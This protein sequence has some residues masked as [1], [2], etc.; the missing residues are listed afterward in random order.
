MDTREKDLLT[1]ALQ[2]TS[3][4][5]E[6]SFNLISGEGEKDD[7]A[8]QLVVCGEKSYKGAAEGRARAQFAPIVE[9]ALGRTVRSG[10]ENPEIHIRF[11]PTPEMAG[12][13][14]SRGL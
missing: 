1:A 14:G 6:I 8:V 11:T 12:R 13:P 7:Y 9:S 5:G 2:S 10:T 4:V 3:Y